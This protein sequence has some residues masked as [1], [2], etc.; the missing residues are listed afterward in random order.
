VPTSKKSMQLLF[1]LMMLKKSKNMEETLDNMIMR[2]EV[3]MTKEDIAWVTEK[4]ENSK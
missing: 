4:V 2:A 3:S 1:D